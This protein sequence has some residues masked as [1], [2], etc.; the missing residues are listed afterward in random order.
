MIQP[1]SQTEG[2]AVLTTGQ[3]LILS[4]FE[5][6]PEPSEPGAVTHSH[7]TSI[8][9]G[10]RLNTLNIAAGREENTLYLERNTPVS[11]FFLTMSSIKFK[12]L[13]INKG[14]TKKQENVT[15]KQEK[16]RRDI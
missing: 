10:T 7:P 5:P 6:R 16:N 11:I 4:A 8:P 14:Y 1:R 2:M 9:D 15:C 13:K 3:N 12:K